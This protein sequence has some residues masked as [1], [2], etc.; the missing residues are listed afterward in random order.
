MIVIPGPSSS[1][2]F[3]RKRF[4]LSQPTNLA[5]TFSSSCMVHWSFPQIVIFLKF[6]VAQCQTCIALLQC[7]DFTG[8]MDWAQLQEV[9]H[10]LVLAQA[11]DR[12]HPQND[13][14]W[15]RQLAGQQLFNCNRSLQLGCRTP[16]KRTKFREK[17]LELPN[18]KQRT[19]SLKSQL[20]DRQG[21]NHFTFWQPH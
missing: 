10:S 12:K 2:L 8:G 14:S 20:P 17:S 6:L 9:L 1:W 13:C 5:T 3:A 18:W 21:G 11:Q 7:G 4:S 19:A 15:L 16:Q